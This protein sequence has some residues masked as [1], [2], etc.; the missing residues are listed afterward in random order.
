MASRMTDAKA[1]STAPRRRAASGD[2]ARP[3]GTRAG[4]GGRGPN[5]AQGFGGEPGGL[6]PSDAVGSGSPASMWAARIACRSMRR[7]ASERPSSEAVGEVGGDGGGRGGERLEPFA[8]GPGEELRPRAP[9]GAPGGGRGG[10]VLSGG[11]DVSD[12]ACCLPCAAALSVKGKYR[13]R[14]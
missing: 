6:A 12:H 7:V 1:I 8:I 13:T 11:G 10:S 14:R 9:V 5:R 3:A 4:R 2:S